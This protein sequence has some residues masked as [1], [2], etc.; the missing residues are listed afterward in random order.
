[1]GWVKLTFPPLLVVP[2]HSP[3]FLSLKSPSAMEDKPT[4]AGAPCWFSGL[5]WGYVKRKVYSGNSCGLPCFS[6]PS[7][8]PTLKDK[9]KVL[10]YFHLVLA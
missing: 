3:G 2:A 10:R 8:V 1:M 9:G 4:P 5:C 7:E 6:L